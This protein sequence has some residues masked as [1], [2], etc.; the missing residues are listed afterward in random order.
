ME[1]NP[2]LARYSTRIKA[3]VLEGIYSPWIWLFFRA[4]RFPRNHESDRG[5]HA[6]DERRTKDAIDDGANGRSG[7]VE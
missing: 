4:L 7:N 2:S 6:S 5:E 1:F 3:S